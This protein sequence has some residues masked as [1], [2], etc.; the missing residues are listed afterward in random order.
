MHKTHRR[1]EHAEAEAE[2]SAEAS[3]AKSELI[4]TEGGELGRD[5]AFSLILEKSAVSD[6]ER[7]Q[8]LMMLKAVRATLVAAKGDPALATSLL[9]A[10]TANEP[11]QM[12]VLS[13]KRLAT[14]FG[15]IQIG[16]CVDGSKTKSVECEKEAKRKMTFKALSQRQ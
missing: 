2:A 11:L 9:Q 15:K 14:Y 7:S 3:A 16:Q 1:R 12:Q 13:E 8:F 6:M 4:S 10:S 5:E